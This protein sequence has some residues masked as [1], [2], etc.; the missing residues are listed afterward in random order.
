MTKEMMFAKEQEGIDGS[1]E[2]ASWN[3]KVIDG[4]SEPASGVERSEL[5]TWYVARIR[6]LSGSEDEPLRLTALLGWT[7]S[8][9]SRA[10]GAARIGILGMNVPAESPDSYLAYLAGDCLAR[11]A[12][13]MEIPEANGPQVN[14]IK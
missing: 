6:A 5:W 4:D 7:E 2:V 11:L 13:D 3:P 14:C 1:P 9:I 12:L 10:E 8:R